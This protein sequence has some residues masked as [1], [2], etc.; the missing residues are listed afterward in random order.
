MPITPRAFEEKERSDLL[1]APSA[2]S[3][4]Y[5][6][7][8]LGTNP[9]DMGWNK[10]RGINDADGFFTKMVAYSTSIIPKQNP[11]KLFASLRNDKGENLYDEGSGV[12]D[13][14]RVSF[15]VYGRSVDDAFWAYD[16]DIKDFQHYTIY[17]LFATYSVSGERAPFAYLAMGK[18]RNLLVFKGSQGGVNGLAAP[19]SGIFGIGSNDWNQNGSIELITVPRTE[20]GAVDIQVHKGFY[21][22][23]QSMRTQIIKIL[24]GSKLP[25]VV[26]GHS[27]GGGVASIAALLL[28]RSQEFSR[29]PIRLYTF[30][31]PPVGNQNFYLIS[32]ATKPQGFSF[33]HFGSQTDPVMCPPFLP[34]GYAIARAHCYMDEVL[35]QEAERITN[36][37]H[38]DPKLSHYFG[39]IYYGVFKLAG[40]AR[41]EKPFKQMIQHIQGAPKN[42]TAAFLSCPKMHE[43]PMTITG[44]LYLPPVLFRDLVDTL[45]GG[46]KNLACFQFAAKIEYDLQ[47]IVLNAIAE[48]I[49]ATET[50]D[51]RIDMTTLSEGIW[52]PR[53]RVQSLDPFLAHMLAPIEKLFP[54]LES[55]IV[56]LL[57][58]N[59]KCQNVKETYE[60][61]VQLKF[62]LRFMLDANIDSQLAKP[63][64]R[65]LLND[66]I[67]CKIT[68]IIRRLHH[69]SS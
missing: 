47:T 46:K 48:V 26:M 21:T 7:G 42:G 51:V 55:F 64:T 68:N 23:Y 52:K 38:K 13:L 29:L 43:I 50:E 6:I 19:V 66:N 28:K 59:Y 40:L 31:V 32:S 14:D 12:L 4:A 27:L 3:L 18:T 49:Q 20:S 37:F 53:E 9:D 2:I 41:P 17:P 16:V 22:L 5:A 57:F 67:Y 63:Y 24:K 56:L 25:L 33:Y 39:Y 30:G 60:N 54:V 10:A 69:E 36:T 15:P 44:L 58:Y 62:Y 11:D 45:P 65:Y 35:K 8:T 61:I 34:S 1:L